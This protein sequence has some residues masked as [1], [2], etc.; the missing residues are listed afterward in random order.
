MAEASGAFP[1]PRAAKD[2]ASS[3]SEIRGSEFKA[4]WVWR[5][6]PTSEVEDQSLQRAVR[7]TEG[8]AHGI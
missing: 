1:T 2:A 5:G 3:A 8:G 4:T 6:S 7:R